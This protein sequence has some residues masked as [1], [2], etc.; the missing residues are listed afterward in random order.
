MAMT[1]QSAG[2]SNVRH[3]TFDITEAGA[4]WLQGHKCF[5]QVP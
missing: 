4:N 5:G 3:T 2:A 1:S